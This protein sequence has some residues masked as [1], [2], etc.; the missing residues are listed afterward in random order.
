MWDVIKHASNG[1]QSQAM[2]SSKGKFYK[3]IPV[4]YFLVDTSHLIKVFAEHIFSIV[5]DGKAQ[6]CGCTK[7][8]ALRLNKDWGYIVNNNRNIILE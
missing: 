2:R 4:P 1:S 5:N 8:Y 6:R 3:E 7:A